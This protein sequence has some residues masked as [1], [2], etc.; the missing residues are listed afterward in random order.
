MDSNFVKAQ[1]DNLP[2]VS[3][4]MVTQFFIESECFNIPESSG[5]KFERF[6]IYLLDITI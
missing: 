4:E 5:V 3:V 1:S 2:K 6:A